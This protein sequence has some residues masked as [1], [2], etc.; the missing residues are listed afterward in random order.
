MKASPLIIVVLV[1]ASC[2]KPSENT[3]SDINH[4]VDSVLNLMTLEEKIGQLN[5]PS[6]GAFVTGSVESSDIA[7]KIEQGKVG[8]LFNIK[9]VANIKEMQK[10]AVEKSRLKI[11]L[12]FG[13]DVIHGYESVFPIPLG[14]SCSWDMKLIERSARIAAQEASADGI[15]WTFSPMVDISRDPRWGRISE[16]SGEDPYLGSEIAKAMVTGFQGDDLSAN[17]TIMSCVKHYALYGASEAGRDYNTVD[18]SRQRMYNDYFP[19]YKAAV[20][21]GVGSVMASFN[22][23]DGIPATANKWL[24]TDVLRNQWGFKGFIVSDYTGLSEMINHG[25]G[26]L[27]TVSAR[28]LD[29]GLDMDMVSEG[30][31][32]TLGKSVSEGKITEQQ[33]TEACRRILEAKFKL[34]LFDNPYKYCDEGRAKS[35]IFTDANRAEARSTATQ[36]FVLLKNKNDVLPISKSGTIA[37][38]GPLAEAKENMTGTWSVAA[39]FSESISV[40]EGLKKA[41]GT[42]AKLVYAKGANLT[43]SEVLEAN[44]TLFGKSLHRDKRTAAELRD[45]AVRIAKNADVI[46]AAVGEAAEMSGEAASR[47]NIE[48]PETQRELLKALLKTG[49]P[50]VLVLFTGRPLVL[51]WEEENIPAILNVWFG[52]SE[53]G[54]AIADVLFGDVNP[55]GKLST[56]FPQNVGQ[57][58]IYYAHKNTGR[59]L[60]GPWF[61]K[62]QSNYLDVSN[63]P[64]YP[65][66]FGLSYTQF[67]YDEIKLSAT[68]MASSDSLQ[69]SIDVTNQGK[70]DG[71]EVVQLYIRDLVGSVTRPV[72]ELKKFQKINLKAGET[73]TVKFMLD[74]DDLSF[75]NSELKFGAEPGKFQVFVGGNSRDVK[76][77]EFSLK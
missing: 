66:G 31:L 2:V 26:D 9:T 35:E 51:T 39:R 11:P 47:T 72:K 60:S 18:M 33:I 77:A 8:G 7:K 21:A 44:S 54:D 28:A 30:L 14:L 73:K 37:L 16:G 3:T 71:S 23:I 68:E 36:S 50:V 13:M 75:Y 63:E 53:A 62:F 58:P 20:D 32:T 34:G 10:I 74:V 4:R 43:E 5:L 59:P 6:A 41:V 76:Q 42:K 49:K 64:L 1:L 24:L 52:G 27:Q 40:L 29:A 46:V 55:S 17:N 67:G 22:E 38:V 65:F 12:I 56:T 48:I 25:M 15:N 45:E 57:V 61:Q 70:R 69:V 19:P